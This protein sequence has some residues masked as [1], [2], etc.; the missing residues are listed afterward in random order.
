MCL[1]CL[2]LFCFSC[3]KDILLSQRDV[4]WNPSNTMCWHITIEALEMMLGSISRKILLWEA[5]NVVSLQQ[6]WINITWF[7]CFVTR[8]EGVPPWNLHVWLESKN[9][10]LKRVPGWEWAWNTVFFISPRTTHS[11]GLPFPL[12]S[13]RASGLRLSES[14]FAETS[15][16]FCLPM[17]LKNCWVCWET[18]TSWGDYG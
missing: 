4:S 18:V 11:F 14:C 8:W 10:P 5:L 9:Y 16:F 7:C 15:H 6:W 2:V 13:P 12:Q 17:T 3:L 1:V